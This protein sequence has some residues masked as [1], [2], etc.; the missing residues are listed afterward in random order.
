M[1]DKILDYVFLL[2]LNTPSE[3]NRLIHQLNEEINKLKTTNDTSTSLSTSSKPIDFTPFMP[4][5]G[6]YGNC[7]GIFDLLTDKGF[8]CNECGMNLNELIDGVEEIWQKQ[9]KLKRDMVLKI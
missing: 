6:N 8:V 5:H 4:A 1:K 2:Q 7:C 3:I 9:K